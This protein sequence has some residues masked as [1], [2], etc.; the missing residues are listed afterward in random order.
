M[1]TLVLFEQSSGKFCLN[2][3]PLILSVSPNVMHFVGTF[4]IMRARGV[5]PICYRKGLKLWKN[6]NNQKRV[7][8][9][10][11]DGMH[12]PHLPLDP[13]LVTNCDEIFISHK[14][15]QWKRNNLIITG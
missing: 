15:N 13:P 10:L 1:A 14:A 4:L 7:R 8:K 12:P 3:V 2:F 11:V 6:C 9:W 5:R